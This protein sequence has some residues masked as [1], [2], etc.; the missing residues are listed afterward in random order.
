MTDS[1][2]ATSCEFV[3]I[4]GLAEVPH[5]PLRSMIFGELNP[6]RRKESSG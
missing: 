4:D 1:A 3:N 6:D 5:T 2:N